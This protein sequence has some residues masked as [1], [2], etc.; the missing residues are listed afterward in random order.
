MKIHFQVFLFF[1]VDFNFI[2]LNSAFLKGS[3]FASKPHLKK[4]V[5]YSAIFTVNMNKL[6]FRL[7]E[8]FTIKSVN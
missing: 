3:D 6:S 1:S 5:H 8:L 4:T 2:I 7:F